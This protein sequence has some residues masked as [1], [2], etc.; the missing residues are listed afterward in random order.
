[1]LQVK[2]WSLLFL[3]G[4]AEERSGT[5]MSFCTKS[6]TLLKM[7]FCTLNGGVELQLDMLKHYRHLSPQFKS[8]ALRCG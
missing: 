7:P 6:A 3:Q 8:D 2:G 1:M 4:V 5:M